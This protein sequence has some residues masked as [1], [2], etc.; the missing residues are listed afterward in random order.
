MDTLTLKQYTRG[1]MTWQRDEDDHGSLKSLM[2][3]LGKRTKTGS[4]RMED[5]KRKHGSKN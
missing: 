2:G 5:M 3:E 4:K 1:G